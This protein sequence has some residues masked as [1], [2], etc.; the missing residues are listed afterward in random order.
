M[1]CFQV[2]VAGL[3]ARGCASRRAYTRLP[4]STRVSPCVCSVVRWAIP[5]VSRSRIGFLRAR[6]RRR[7]LSSIRIRLD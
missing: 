6:I 5:G 4:L 1:A 7:L 2:R 3:L